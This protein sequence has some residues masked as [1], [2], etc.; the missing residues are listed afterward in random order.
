MN[1]KLE[2]PGTEILRRNSG[3]SLRE[4]LSRERRVLM[5]V[6][7]GSRLADV[8]EEL[9]LSVEASSGNHM[10]A[11]ILLV[12]DD[13]RYLQ[14][15]AA[16]SLPPAYNKE[17]DGE[18]VGEGVGSCGTAAYRGSPVYVADIDTDPLWIDYRALAT[19]HGLRACWSTPIKGMDGS[20]LG[21]F[22]VYYDAPRS[23]RPRDL[24][25]IAA[26]TL[27]VALVIERHRCDLELQR[28]RAELSALA[29]AKS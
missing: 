10:M 14:H 24:E 3:P 28:L 7:A 12:S 21:T 1:V 18:R 27:T 5:Q 4:H 26:I 11:S 2:L 15:L 6:A 29:K 13:G 19:Q 22:A 25:A 9:L 23:P 20:T 17:I 16:P 8:L